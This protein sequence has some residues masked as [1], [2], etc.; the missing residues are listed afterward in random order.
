MNKESHSIKTRPAKWVSCQHTLCIYVLSLSINIIYRVSPQFH[1]LISV[2]KKLLSSK[3][4]F[5]VFKGCRVLFK[6]M[7]KD[8]SEGN[9]TCRRMEVLYRGLWVILISLFQLERKTLVWKQF[10]STF[11]GH[12]KEN[13]FLRVLLDAETQQQRKCNVCQTIKCF[14]VISQKS[15]R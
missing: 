11:T 15:I 5:Y 1:V 14:T 13:K 12:C 10:T 3:N 7:S 2:F 8:Q 9:K 4:L 6:R